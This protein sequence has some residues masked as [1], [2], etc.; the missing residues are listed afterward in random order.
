MLKLVRKPPPETEGPHGFSE[1]FS[2]V[3]VENN[4]AFPW[5]ASEKSSRRDEDLEGEE[6]GGL[7]GHLEV[8]PQELFLA[9]DDKAFGQKTLM[10]S[11]MA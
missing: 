9:P 5:L 6:D 3:V 11:L 7:P 8:D 10:A 2:T 1:L 4:E